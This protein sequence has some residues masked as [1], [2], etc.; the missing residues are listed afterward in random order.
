MNFQDSFFH[1]LRNRFKDK[2]SLAEAVREA[3]D[4]S[5]DGA[6][7]RISGRS[8]LQIDE[9]LTL[10]RA[11]NVHLPGGSDGEV[12]FRFNN[13]NRSIGSPADYIDQLEEQLKLVHSW[14]DKQL[15]YA[16]PDLPFLYELMSPNLMAFK[17]YIFGVTS[18]G[19][20]EWK[21]KPFSLRLIDPAVLD[22]ARAIS[23]YAYRVPSKEI[24]SSG[25]L[26]ATLSQL[27]Y[28]AMVSKFSEKELPFT[29]LDEVSSIVDHLEQMAQHGV[30]FVPGEDPGNSTVPFSIHYNELLY[31]S[32][33]ISI[34]SPQ[35]SLL[36]LSFITPNYL[37][38]TDRELGEE[39]RNWFEELLG[40]A[41]ELGQNTKKLRDWYFNRLRAQIDNTRRR[42]EL[43]L[44]VSDSLL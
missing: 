8:N 40:E 44:N 33:T 19:F 24:W 17:L 21:N 38:T 25:L 6:Y 18:W 30:K 20:Q 32:T 36:F 39:V 41:T 12:R 31:I 4:I 28:M 16:T 9:L 27:E 13:R 23:N 2:K 1:Q 34:N 11:F 42:L 43:H 37:V 10:A 5:I 14:P 26:N 22:K 35:A 15:Y 29:I 7:R 3:L